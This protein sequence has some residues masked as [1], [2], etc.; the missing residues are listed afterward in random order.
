LWF[1]FLRPFEKPALDNVYPTILW[2][3][4]PKKPAGLLHDHKDNQPAST[5]L[6]TDSLFP[7]RTLI[8]PPDQ[9]NQKIPKGSF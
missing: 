8:N 5:A 1:N 9:G 2:L 4:Q 7:N 3:K 6:I